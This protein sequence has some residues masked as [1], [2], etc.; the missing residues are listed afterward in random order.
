[1]SSGSR[2]PRQTHTLRHPESPVAAR[3]PISLRLHEFRKF[4][5]E[6]APCLGKPDC[7]YNQV[8]SGGRGMDSANSSRKAACV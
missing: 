6:C 7:Y 4:I 2:P 1:M 3:D 8:R 5:P